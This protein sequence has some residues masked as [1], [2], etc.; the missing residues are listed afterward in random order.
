LDCCD[1]V[2]P[3]ATTQEVDEDVCSAVCEF[4]VSVILVI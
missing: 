4:V 3:H 2:P 1:D